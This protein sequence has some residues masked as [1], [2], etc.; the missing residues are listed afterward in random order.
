MIVVNV[1]ATHNDSTVLGRG[2]SDDVSTSGRFGVDRYIARC[3][4][5]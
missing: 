5:D 1:A 2:A 3:G 4:A